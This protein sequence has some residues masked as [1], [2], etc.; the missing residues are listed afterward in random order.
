MIVCE[1]RE[2]QPACPV[3]LLEVNKAAQVIFE[4]LILTFYL[5]V[6]KAVD[7]LRCAPK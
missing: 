2:R 6:R 4:S 3:I 7:N 1:L 5:P